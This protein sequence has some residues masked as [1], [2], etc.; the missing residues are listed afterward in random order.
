MKY[1]TSCLVGSVLLMGWTGAAK[2]GPIPYPTPG[3]LNPVTYTFTAM[4]DGEVIA[5]FAGS[6]ASYTE[7]LGMLVNGALSPNGFGLVN[8][9][10]G[11]YTPIGTSFD[12]GTVKKGDTITF[13]V[14]VQVPPI[15]ALVYSDPTLNGPFDFNTPGAG[16]NHIYS[17]D[18]DG[19]NPSLPGVPPGTYVA[20]EDLPF[21]QS[22][23]NYHDE[24]YVFTN[25]AAV[26]TNP[27]APEPATIALL[28]VGIAGMSG[29]GWRRRKLA[30]V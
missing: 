18:Y 1:L 25:V 7:A 21:P 26:G 6:T 20:F 16:T 23:L 15:A 10:G 30:A 3:T 4:N 28:G 12:L 27:N 17:T 2:A 22:D 8:Q 13:A 19:I 29:Y 11:I 24:T 14:Q 9:S 5:Y